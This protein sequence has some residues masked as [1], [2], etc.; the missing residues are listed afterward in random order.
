METFKDPLRGLVQWVTTIR[1]MASST[2]R[3]LHRTM[4]IPS[5]LW[6]TLTRLRCL[7]WIIGTLR[8]WRRRNQ[9]AVS[10]VW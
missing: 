5:S 10:L 6:L 9:R 2:F 8:K 7:S 1:T 3:R 4:P